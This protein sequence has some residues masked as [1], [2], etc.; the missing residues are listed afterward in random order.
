MAVILARN[1]QY[2]CPRSFTNHPSD[3]KTAFR[4]FLFDSKFI[5]GVERAL[6]F[7]AFIHEDQV[8]TG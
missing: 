7:T 8:S 1:L 2:F 6:V 5:I 3:F 4:A